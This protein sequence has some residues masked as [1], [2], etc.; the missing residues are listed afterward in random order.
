LTLSQTIATTDLPCTACSARD[1]ERLWTGT[2]HEYRGETTDRPFDVVRCRRC[3]LARLNP[4]PDVSELSRIYPPSY[5]AY[6][7][8]DASDAAARGSVVRRFTERAKARR[9]QRRLLGIVDRLE[10]SPG[11]IR[12]LDVGCAD[13]RL[14]DW[15][16]ESA[17]GDRLETYGIDISEAAVG[18]ARAKG[19][20]AVAGRFELDTELPEGTFDVILAFHVIEHV[21][22]P[23][24]FAR[25]AAALLR[26]GGIF[27]V[28]TPNIDSVDAR[29]FGRYW[30][31]NHF[32]RHWTFYSPETLAELARSVGLEAGRIEWEVN[33]VFWNWTMHAW[34]TA[35]FPTARWPDRLFPPVRIFHASTQ[36]F[37][38]LSFFTIVDTVLRVVT[39]RTASMAVDLRK[40]G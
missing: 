32:P 1:D 38:L 16:R 5:Y 6:H 13:G 39:G 30:G 34:L 22:D 31:G 8:S 20:R 24:A 3:G 15:Y 2:E 14:L 35:R 33:P 29:R 11:P 17:A 10:A 7:L 40:P 4:R 21:D 36:S 37:M 25:R 28:A 19:H 9:Y 18:A 23:A 26:P 27:V 12:L